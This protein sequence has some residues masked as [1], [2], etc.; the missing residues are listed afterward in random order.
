MISNAD[1]RGTS[2]GSPGRAYRILKIAAVGLVVLL[3]IGAA[4]LAAKWPFTRD[5]MA[6]QLGDAAS[7]T[8]H[9]KSFKAHYLPPGCVMEEVQFSKSKDASSP[10]LMTV[11]RMTITANYLGLFRGHVSAMH[12]EDV[13][14]D[15]AQRHAGDAQK[16]GGQSSS[17][18][19]IGEVIVDRAV[20]DF[21]RKQGPPLRFDIHQLTFGNVVPGKRIAFHATLDNPLPPGRVR[22]DGQFGP[23]NDSDIAQT[24]LTGAYQLSDADLATLGGIAGILSSQGSFD[25]PAAA[26]RVQGKTDTPDYRVKKANHPVHLKTEFQAVVDCRNGNVELQG[27]RVQFE[28]TEAAVQGEVVKKPGGPPRTASL[29]AADPGGRIEDWLRLLSDAPTPGMKGPMSFRAH[30]TIPGGPQPFIRRVHLLGD[31]G[32]TSATFTHDDTQQKLNN[33]SLRSQGQKISDDNREDSPKAL[34]SLQ[35]QV[36]LRDGVAHFTELLFTIP[37]ASAHMHGT[38]SLIDQRVDLHGELKVDTKFS[39]TAK[40]VKVALIKAVEL[41]A[42]SSKGNGEVLPVKLTGTYSHPSYGL[43]K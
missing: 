3:G 40:G 12:L 25:G 29:S 42:A 28:K 16:S 26:L 10:P 17:S 37:G 32:I 4:L 7:S 14:V 27:V 24:V 38:Y 2:A 18:T 23:W 8:V 15:M 31:F 30:L 33:L 22:V 11:A 36:E 35:G 13:Q 34:S 1:E 39:K 5:N 43:D 19:T 21:P 9:I 41:L 20:L 6:A